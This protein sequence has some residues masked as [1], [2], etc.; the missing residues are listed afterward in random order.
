MIATKAYSRRFSPFHPFVAKGISSA[1]FKW[2]AMTNIILFSE[3]IFSLILVYLNFNFCVWQSSKYS[4]MVHVSI[5][6]EN[7]SIQAI[8]N[9]K[10][11]TE[12]ETKHNV[13]SGIS[14]NNSLNLSKAIEKRKQVTCCLI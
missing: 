9:V 5:N 2:D 13:P 7:P 11:T 8:S 12:K 4:N 3:L 1:L 14:R 6:C 10:E